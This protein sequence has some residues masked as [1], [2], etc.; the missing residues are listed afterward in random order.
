MFEML[1]NWSFGDYFKKEAIGLGNF[2]QKSTKFKENLY[3]SVFE[4]NPAE[5]VPFDQEAWDIWKELIDEDRIILGNK[6][7]NFGK[8]AIKDLVDRVQKFTLTFVQQ[9][10]SFSF[11]KV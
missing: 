6:K 10:E 1:G 8:W 7:D 2:W 5:N 3:V 11:R 9:R 4:G